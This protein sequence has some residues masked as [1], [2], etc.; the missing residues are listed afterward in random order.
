[1]AWNTVG[2]GLSPLELDTG[3]TP[4]ASTSAYDLIG[5]DSTG[6][7]KWR[8][9]QPGRRD[10]RRPGPPGRNGGPTQ[11][12]ALMAGSPAIN[13]GSTALAVDQNGN[14]LTTDQR[15]AGFPRVNG[16]VDIGASSARPR[17]AR[18]P[19]TRRSHQRQWHGVGELG[20]PGLRHRPGRRQPNPAGSMIQF[21][22][23]YS[24]RR[25]RS[26]CP[27]RFN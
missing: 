18:P 25:R 11:T 14:P 5:V 22:P 3:G 21:A 23:R 2:G 27:A 4:F 19:C 15:G 1:M 17:S 13:A 16:T 20:G 8:Q 10:Q 12:I 9:R 24:A 6:S 7:F 26:R